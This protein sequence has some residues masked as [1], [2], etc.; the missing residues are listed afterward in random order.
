MAQGDGKIKK[1]SKRAER[2]LR[3][4]KKSAQ[5]KKGARYIAPRRTS[6]SASAMKEKTVKINARLEATIRKKTAAH[7]KLVL[8]TKK[9]VRKG[10]EKEIIIGKT[11][12]QICE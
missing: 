11:I 8:D 5:R 10:K 2:Q 4:F 7:Q 3:P 9:K 6:E 12:A 1:S